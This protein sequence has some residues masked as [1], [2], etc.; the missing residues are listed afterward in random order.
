MQIRTRGSQVSNQYNKFTNQIFINSAKEEGWK[1][2]KL[3]Y[4]FLDNY[5][6]VTTQNKII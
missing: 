4:K 1:K 6:R 2:T 3:L 5:F